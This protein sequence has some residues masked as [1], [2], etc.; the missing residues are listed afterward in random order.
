[1]ADC[2]VDKELTEIIERHPVNVTPQR[3]AIQNYNVYSNEYLKNWTD[4][5]C[6]T[7]WHF[8]TKRTKLIRITK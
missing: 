5:Y 6:T 3:I 7:V 2:Y 8:H 1:M 4:I